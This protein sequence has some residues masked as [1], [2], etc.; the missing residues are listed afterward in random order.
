MPNDWIVSVIIPC[1]NSPDSLKRLLQEFTEQTYP[2]DRTELII[3]DDGSEQPVSPIVDQAREILKDFHNVL[4][5]IHPV[6]RGRSSTR[7]SGIAASTGRTLIFFDVDCLPDPHFIEATVTI[8]AQNTRVAIRSDIRVLPEFCRKSAYLRYRDSRFIGA[9]NPEQRRLL[10]VDNLSPNFCATGGLSVERNDMLAVGCFDEAF[11]GYG[12]EDEEL[13]L[14]LRN[15]GVRLIWGADAH[16]WDA[17]G[18]LTFAGVCAKY[19]QYGMDSGALLFMK[20][21]EYMKNTPFGMLEPIHVRSEGPATV[22]IKILLRFALFPPIAHLI[23]KLLTAID[24]MP[25]N[26]PGFLYKYVLSACYLEGVQARGRK[27]A[28]TVK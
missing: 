24:R 17:D 23:G 22:A 13:G 16:M 2:H 11:R 19:N 12:G 18:S 10:D 28:A 8:H 26:P 14:R 3:V 20:H 25:M 15:G 4:L 6:N 7:N 5:I 1:Y 9:R 21:P 27:K